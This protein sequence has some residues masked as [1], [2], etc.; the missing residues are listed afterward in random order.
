MHPSFR[1]SAVTFLS[2]LEFLSDIR[3]RVRRVQ[4]RSLMEKVYTPFS[5]TAS[6]R[7]NP[8]AVL[9]EDQAELQRKVENHFSVPEYVLPRVENGA[10][11]E[12]D[13]F[14]LVRLFILVI[15]AFL[16]VQI[17]QVL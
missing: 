17:S 11:T 12:E 7:S 5:P 3:P 8:P 1:L 4:A 16:T 2:P 9:S 13:K 15:P 6:V 14:W 10:L